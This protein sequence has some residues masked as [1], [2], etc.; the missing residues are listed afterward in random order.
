MAKEKPV[1]KEKSEI[2]HDN[3]IFNFLSIIHYCEQFGSDYNPANEDL[4]IANMADRWTEVG[5]MQKNYL[6]AVVDRKLAINLRQ[7]KIALL[8]SL[9][10][11]AYNSL[12]STKEMKSS[13]EDLKRKMKEITGDNVRRKKDEEGNVEKNTVSNSHLGVADVLGNFQE[14]IVM[15]ELSTFYNAQEDILKVAKLKLFYE[16]V[17]SAIED[18]YLKSAVA[19]TLMNVRDKGLYGR[20][21]LVD[22]SL[23][24]KM[25]M[26]SLFGAR[27]VEAKT[28][29]AIKLKRLKRIAEL[30]E[31]S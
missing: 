12:A 29:S 19:S 11:R 31:G 25:Y 28:V 30:P 4:T 8:K 26:R 14:F 6:K 22:V 15:L 24:C 10:R 27:S 7:E 3:N 21:G 16:E 1:V 18:V 5:E 13:I 9:V 23:G 2:T 20:D 17:E